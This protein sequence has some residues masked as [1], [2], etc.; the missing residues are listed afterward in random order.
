VAG[1]ILELDGAVA[2]PPV[3]PVV[4]RALPIASAI[5]AAVTLFVS[6]GFHDPAIRAPSA[7]SLILEEV[8]KKNQSAVS[9]TLELRLPQ[10]LAAEIQTREVDGVTGLA[11]SAPTLR[12]FRI[13]ESNTVVIVA[14]IPGAPAIVQPTNLPVD[15]L[16]VHGVYAANYSVEAPSLTAVR[17]TENG[18]TYEIAS[19]SLLLRELVV[20]AEQVR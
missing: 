1:V 10:D 5:V 12:S 16:S 19:Q 6:A 3:S 14:W 4:G 18:M 7:K 2:Q 17:W 15:V 13:R 8:F 20:L 11:R 9:P